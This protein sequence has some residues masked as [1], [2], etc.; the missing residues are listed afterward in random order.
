MKGVL[1]Y[2]IGL[3]CCVLLLGVLPVSGEERIYDEV[4]R[5]H[6]LANS[7]SEADQANKLAVRDAILSAYREELT[8]LTRDEAEARIESLLPAIRQ[9][10]E[11]TLIARGAPAPVTVTFTDEMYPERVYGEL[12]F[13]AGTYRSLRVLI[14]EGSGQN[15]WCV[16][17]PPLCVGA[18]AEEVAISAPEQAAGVI[19]EGGWRLVSQSG[20]YQIRFRLLEWLMGQ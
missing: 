13:P 16:L 4:I 18:A 2:T 17:F 12:H 6:V 7:D 1:M 3:L 8:A 15:W 19:G 10:A 14:G 11:Q 5:L 20:D 9:L